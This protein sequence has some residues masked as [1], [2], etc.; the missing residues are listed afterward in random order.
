MI[1]DHEG[2]P[3]YIIVSD[4]GFWNNRDGWCLSKKDATRFVHMEPVLPIGSGV[5]LIP[6]T[7]QHSFTDEEGNQITE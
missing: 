4:E 5:K 7:E 3:K 2:T 1:R 6:E